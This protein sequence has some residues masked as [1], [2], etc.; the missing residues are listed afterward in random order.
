MFNNRLKLEYFLNG[1][2]KNNI[3]S[4]FNYRNHNFCNFF[5]YITKTFVN[6]DLV[7]SWNDLMIRNRLH[8]PFVIKDLR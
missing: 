7:S 2:L 8:I 4:I 3:D 1:L 6:I 5:C